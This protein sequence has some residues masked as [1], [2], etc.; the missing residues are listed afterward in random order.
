[1]VTVNDYTVNLKQASDRKKTYQS[2]LKRSWEHDACVCVYV[3]RYDTIVHN[4]LVCMTTF[5]VA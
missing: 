3:C 5:S 2:D 4:N 1:M